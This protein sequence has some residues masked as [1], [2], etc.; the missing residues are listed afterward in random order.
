MCHVI[1]R[2]LIMV[3]IYN[4]TKVQSRV[5]LDSYM[6]KRACRLSQSGFTQATRTHSNL[7]RENKHINAA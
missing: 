4:A 5:Q 1:D 2:Q 6:Y 7:Y 3:N